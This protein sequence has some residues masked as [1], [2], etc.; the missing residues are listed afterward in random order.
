MK[1][2]AGQNRQKSGTSE[3]RQPEVAAALKWPNWERPTDGE[4]LAIARVL[5]RYAQFLKPEVVSAVV[6]DNARHANEWR[7]LLVERRIDP[8]IYLWKGSPCAFPGVRRHAGETE[9][10]RF[11]DPATAALPH[12]HCLRL[13]DN[14][15][16]KHLWAFVF[17]GR[18][19]AKRGPKGYHLAHGGP[20]R[21]SE[22]LAK[23][24]QVGEGRKRPIA[25]RVVC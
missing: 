3:G 18:K 12:P 16:P 15:Y 10:K 2:H 7:S 6:E 8:D 25:L 13:D 11:K 4:M 21:V 19:S 14:D 23:R 1:Q 5:A 9:R 24:V 17:T 22:P 20:Q